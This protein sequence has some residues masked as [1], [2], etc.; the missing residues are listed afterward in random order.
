[1]GTCRTPDHVTRMGFRVC[2][3]LSIDER[4]AGDVGH[5]VELRDSVGLTPGVDE[6]V[7]IIAIAL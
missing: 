6:R 3:P 5:L 1:L 4:R 2:A 7:R